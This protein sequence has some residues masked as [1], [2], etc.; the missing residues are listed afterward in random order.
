M[1]IH[2]KYER[3]KTCM[4]LTVVH[5]AAVHEGADV[6]DVLRV[7]DLLG[8]D[9]ADAAVGDGRGHHARALASQLQGAELKNK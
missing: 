5:P 7:E 2:N 9:G 6:E 8:G 1:L 3:K 4:L